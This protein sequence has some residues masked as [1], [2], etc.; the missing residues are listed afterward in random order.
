MK[1]IKDKQKF[2]VEHYFPHKGKWE[3][4]HGKEYDKLRRATRA[5][6]TTVL[7]SEDIYDYRIVKKEEKET[8]VHS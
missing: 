8:I 4:D 6:S 2:L 5:G 7:D 1:V 3:R